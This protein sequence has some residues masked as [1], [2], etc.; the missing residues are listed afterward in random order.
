MGEQAKCA[1][2]GA[3]ETLE[4][5]DSKP[6]MTLW[7]R[8]LRLVRGQRF[9]LRWAADHGHDFTELECG[10]CYGDGYEVSP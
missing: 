1:R 9:A 10:S 4:K 3:D 5:L 2:C 6:R 7:L 8:L